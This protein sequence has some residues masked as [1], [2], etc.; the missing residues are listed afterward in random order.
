M[1]RKDNIE[2]MIGYTDAHNEQRKEEALRCVTS[3]VY[4]Y[5]MDKL[6]LEDVRNELNKAIEIENQK[7]PH[8]KWLDKIETRGL[9]FF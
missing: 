6:S 4:S 2:S 9:G 7:D 5:R 8:Q 3:I 1:V